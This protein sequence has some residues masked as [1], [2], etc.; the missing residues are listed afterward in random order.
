MDAPIRDAGS[1]DLY[2]KW[3][4]P[5]K[6]FNDL[7]EVGS[8]ELKAQGIDK[9]ITIHNLPNL[10]KDETRPLTFKV[11][12][13]DTI[14]SSEYKNLK[15][16]FNLLNR[17]KIVAG[18]IEPAPYRGPMIRDSR[19]YQLLSPTT[20]YRRTEK[21]MPL[22]KPS[23]IEVGGSYSIICTHEGAKL[24]K[25]EPPEPFDVLIDQ[26]AELQ[27]RFVPPMMGWGVMLIQSLARKAD[28]VCEYNTLAQLQKLLDAGKSYSV[29]SKD[30]QYALPVA[31]QI[32]ES[33]IKARR[34]QEELFA[35][36]CDLV[37]DGQYKDAWDAIPRLEID[38][39]NQQAYALVIKA[40]HLHTWHT[41]DDVIDDMISQM[42]QG[43]HKDEILE[44]VY[45]DS[46]MDVIQKDTVL[47]FQFWNRMPECPLKQELFEALK[48]SQEALEDQD[49]DT[50]LLF[51][52]PTPPAQLAAPVPKQP[53]EEKEESC[54]IS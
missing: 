31:I 1:V 47:A 53:A 37:S 34:V 3:S 44:Y 7:L 40:Y 45:A 6:Y 32:L 10:K 27:N 22:E 51:D 21:E 28:E 17:I 50:A 2:V 14:F 16:S 5:T 42:P 23:N 36:I 19:T 49:L 41:Q 48:A 29:N 35:K 33:A 43:K 9:E 18:I 13:K 8:L 12:N 52:S 26:I 24:V 46:I 30:Q 11:K 54:I 25:C 20:S 38:E 4:G 39:L 15:I